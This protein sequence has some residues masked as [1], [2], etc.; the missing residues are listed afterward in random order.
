MFAEIRDL[1]SAVRPSESDDPGAGLDA[2]RRAIARLQQQARSLSS[3]IH[4]RLQV[5]QALRE[6]NDDR[7]T[8]LPNRSVF[9]DRLAFDIKAW[10]A[11]NSRSP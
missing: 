2:L 9:H 10:A 5:E 4:D 3:D 11:A 1:H 8:G 7:L 6:V